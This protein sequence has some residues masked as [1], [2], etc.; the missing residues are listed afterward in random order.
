[1]IKIPA[2]L[3]WLLDRRAR[4]LGEIKK[5]NK[6]FD[7]REALLKDEQ[8]VLEKRL[9]TVRSRLARVQALR[10]HVPAQLQL[11]LNAIDQAIHQHNAMV[12]VEL[13]TPR[14]SQDN[15]WYLPHGAMSRYILRALREAQGQALTTDEIAIF[16]ATEGGLTLIP[17]QYSH[18]KIAVRS[19]MRSMRIAGLLQRVSVGKNTIESR[20][21][22][23]GVGTEFSSNAA[24]R[25]RH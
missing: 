10:L 7:I 1:M 25:P 5:V 16:V 19:R 3:K 21:A 17:D 14:T 4:L 18:F 20:W 6:R 12:D 11:K 22:A 8:A 24:G 23:I 9:A 2:A 13:V 15:A